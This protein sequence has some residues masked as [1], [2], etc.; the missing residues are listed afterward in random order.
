MTIYLDGL[1]LFPPDAPPEGRLAVLMG[2]ADY[3]CSCGEI[4]QLN[5][6]Q[7]TKFEP[8]GKMPELSGNRFVH[9]ENREAVLEMS[10][11]ASWD[12]TAYRQCRDWVR[13][14]HEYAANN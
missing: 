13:R 1:P 10:P 3:R 9:G 6:G 2:S 8:A 11:F 4:I 14:V 12:E 7:L 5:P